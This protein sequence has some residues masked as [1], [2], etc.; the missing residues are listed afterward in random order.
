MNI[1]FVLYHDFTANSAGHVRS[2]ANELVKLGHDCSVAVP[3]NKGSV[4]SLGEVLFHPLEYADAFEAGFGFSNEGGPD[5][6][7]AW[8]PREGVRKYCQRILKTSKSRLFIHMEDNEWHLLT[9]CLGQSLEALMRL[10]SEELDNLVPDSLSHPHRAMD[11][12]RA[13]DGV[14][15][16]IDRLREILP[17]VRTTME[18][19]PSAD[20]KLFRPGAKHALGRARMGIPENSTV[21]VYTGNVHVAN[22]HEVRSLYLAVAILNREG[23]PATLLRAGR[24]FYPFLGPDES[25]ARQHSVELGMMPHSEVP[26]LLAFADLLVQPGNSD[27]FNDYRFPSKLPEFLS[28]GRPVILPN[29]NIARYMKPHHGY[30]LEKSNAVTIADAIRK[31]TSDQD[32][33]QRLS[34]GAIEFFQTHLS[35]SKSARSLYDFYLCAFAPADQSSLKCQVVGV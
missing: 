7:H 19:W 12:L 28:A 20:E 4:S 9:C 32:L 18:L 1:L 17:P 35:W 10:E 6:I 34:V 14:T 8:T 31:I 2:L 21:I 25:W 5:V 27:E 11:F 33:Y 3:N 15:V 13:A 22:A 23:F 26:S 30:I 24:D 29:A 16:I